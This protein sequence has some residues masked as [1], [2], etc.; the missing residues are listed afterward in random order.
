MEP[1]PL[2][3]VAGS[4]APLSTLTIEEMIEAAVERAISRTLGP[5]LHRLSA[6]EPAVYTV[7]Q[8]AE[9]L[10]VSEDTIGRM[11]RKGVIARVPHVGGKVL[12]P[13][14]ALDRIIEGSELAQTAPVAEDGTASAAVDPRRSRSIRSAAS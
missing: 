9:V 11:V 7:A 5:Y 3:T 12:I 2:Q 8:S 6:C 1:L 14:R 13:K 4:A 10:Q